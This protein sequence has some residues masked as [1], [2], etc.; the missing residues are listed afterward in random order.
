MYERAAVC[1]ICGEVIYVDVGPTPATPSSGAAINAVVERAA[2]E[3]LAGHPTAV[4]ER[5]L[6]RKHLD[7]LAPEVRPVAVKQ[8]YAQLRELWGDEDRVPVYSIDEALGCMA[9][10]R[11]WCNASR[12]TWES[13]RHNP[14]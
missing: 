8:V 6:L 1:E 9:V 14:A 3:H 13:C 11:L 5:F 4:V 7:E 12:C 10:Y 2:Q